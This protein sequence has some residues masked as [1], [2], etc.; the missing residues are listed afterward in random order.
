MWIFDLNCRTKNRRNYRAMRYKIQAQSIWEYGQRVDENG[1]PHQED[2]M[3]PNHGTI[4]PNDRL[5]IVCDGMGGHEAGEI[6]SGIVCQTLSDRILSSRQGFSDILLEKAI[7]EAF[8]ALNNAEQGHPTGMKMGTTMALLKL[9]RKGATIAHIGDSRI[10]HFRP[11]NTGSDTRIL[12]KTDDHSLVNELVKLGE[13]THEEARQSR[14][15]NIITRAMQPTVGDHCRA[16]VYHTADIKKDDVFFLCTDG[17]LENMDDAQL[18]YFF[19]KQVCEEERCN[20]LIR[21]TE[22]NRDNHSAIIITIQQSHTFLYTSRF[23]R[24]LNGSLQPRSRQCLALNQITTDE[25][26]TKGT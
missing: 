13:L 5:F 21:A 15:K 24:W 12:F 8:L 18:C 6:A 7:D 19:S 16:D 23:P 20:Q 17:M 9:H 2:N 4:M 25:T 1:N 26:R 11:G 14:R 3:F 10:Y 22:E